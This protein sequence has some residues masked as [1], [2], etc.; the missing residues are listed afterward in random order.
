[1]SPQTALLSVL[2]G[3]A[4]ASAHGAT[5]G[6]PV[7]RVV[8]LL[9]ELRGKITM[10]GKE[11]QRIY[12]K[13][14]CWCERTIKRKAAAIHENEMHLRLLGQKILK[15]K[16]TIATL[17]SEIAELNA[18]IAEIIKALE[19]LTAVRQKENAAYTAEST[20]MMQALA[21]L[22]KAIVVLRDA[23]KLSLLQ[24]TAASHAAWS[25]AASGV[26]AAVAAMPTSMALPVERASA[27]T[28]FLE[29]ASRLEAGYAP[30]SA[31]VQGIL[32]DMYETFAGDLEQL[33]TD[34]AAKNR[35]F[36]DITFVKTK[37][38]FELKEELAKKKK[39]LAET[40][41]LLADTQEEYDAEEALMN[42]NI[43]FFDQT[44]AACLAKHD[45]WNIRAAERKEELAGIEEAL[46]ILTSDEARELFAKSIKP[47][48]EP[49]FL[50]VGGA[51]SQAS[52]VTKA[53]RALR[54]Q[55]AKTHSLRL[56]ALAATV[57][58]ADVGHFDKVIKMIDEMIGVLKE[59]EAADIKKRDQ[60]KEEYTKIASVIADLE[61]QIEK[62]LAKIAKLESLIKAREDDKEEALAA[63]AQT[64][65]EIAEMEDQRKEEN[66]AFLQ[67]KSDDEGAIALLEAAKE[68]LAA[69]YNKH[70]IPLGPVQGSV[71]GV[72]LLQEPEFAVSVDQ[73]P[74]ATFQ[75]KGSRKGESK[76]II[77]IITMIIE[78]LQAEIKTGIAG[79]AA[80]QA[81]FEKGLAAAKKLIAELE[82]KV[83]QLTETIATRKEE[84]TQEHSL[85][86]DNNNSLDEE[87]AYKKEIT[88][89]CDWIINAFEERRTKRKAEMDALVQA[90]EF[91]AGAQTPS[92]LQ[93]VHFNDAA[94]PKIGFT[95]ISFLQKSG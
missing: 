43:E 21:A 90:K 2:F 88:G 33:T 71:K 5:T 51:G 47:G 25:Q 93:Q 87:K 76:G 92:M 17:Q 59:E 7:E 95:G 9:E 45:E 57:R 16:G 30:Q 32:K 20:E 84:W 15:Y 31:T 52:A 23:T 78:D 80:T 29:G 86:K 81:E 4:A 26:R 54:A 1:M 8:K 44:K 35:Q 41:V 66:E 12:D 63:I 61:W 77:S 28:A 38:M 13:Y 73:A 27:V 60:C 82:S 11:D 48:L 67:A 53:Y 42:E 39:A 49:T 19:T 74:D 24:D 34:E 3:A 6:T 22:E 75:H 69:Y 65:E 56:A 58:A 46:K 50:Q 79:E 70:K 91:L 10:D 14:A 89:D 40:E 55:S 68:A 83:D 36:E 72:D 85:M 37:L 94:F 18:T 62:N 64:K